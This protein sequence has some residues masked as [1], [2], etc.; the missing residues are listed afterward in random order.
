MD[1]GVAKL[2]LGGFYAQVRRRDLGVKQAGKLLVIFGV[3]WALAFGASTLKGDIPRFA[4]YLTA[5]NLVGAVFGTMFAVN[6]AFGKL[7]DGSLPTWAY[8]VWWPWL[9]IQFS[10]IVIH[11]RFVCPFLKGYDHPV[12]VEVVPGWWIGGYPGLEF[13]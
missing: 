8:L 1:L 13:R 10:A 5:A 11:R 4:G 2:D 12:V 9:L 7:P 3:A 6:N